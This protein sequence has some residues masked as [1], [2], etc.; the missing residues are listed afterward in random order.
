MTRT[1]SSTLFVASVS[2]GALVAA[3]SSSGCVSYAQP[4][5][6]DVGRGAEP[7]PTGT[8]QAHGAV[9]GGPMNLSTAD[10]PVAVQG[11]AGMLAS[12][13]GMRMAG[14]ASGAG[15]GG[16]GSAGGSGAGGTLQRGGGAPY[17]AGCARDLAATAAG[18]AASPAY[19]G[20][21]ALARRR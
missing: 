18:S 8:M 11:G 16:E 4:H 12:M 9:W 21:A 7:L 13:V 6:F 3:S 17:A 5:A 10:F 19:R 2:L 1:V 14:A 15:A 20:V